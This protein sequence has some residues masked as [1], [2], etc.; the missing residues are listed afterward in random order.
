MYYSWLK[1]YNQLYNDT[2]HMFE[3]FFIILVA[4]V[5]AVIW[6]DYLLVL[7]LENVHIYTPTGVQENQHNWG[8]YSY[9][10]A[11]WED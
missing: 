7:D 6:M 5:D 1:K 2:E 10:Q 9:N 4:P 3:F 11:L 8:K